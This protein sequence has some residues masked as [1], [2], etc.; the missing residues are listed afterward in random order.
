MRPAIAPFGRTS[1]SAGSSRLLCVFLLFLVAKDVG[2]GKDA[3]ADASAA[4]SAHSS[5]LTQFRHPVH[6][7]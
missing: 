2:S 4:T 3:S 5:P 7:Q 1:P 6:L